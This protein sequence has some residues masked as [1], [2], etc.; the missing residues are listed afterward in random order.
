MSN[1]PFD[2]LKN[3]AEHMRHAAETMSEKVLGEETQAHLREAACHMIKA[4]RSAL[5]HAE[6]CLKPKPSDDFA[7]D[8]PSGVGSAIV[9][10]DQ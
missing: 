2:D 1:S 7:A 8:S 9:F 10:N 5:D 6:G 4:A 3:A